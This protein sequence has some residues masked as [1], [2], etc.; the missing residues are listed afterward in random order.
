MLNDTAAAIDS[1]PG[2]ID[3]HAKG[4]QSAKKIRSFVCYFGI[5]T[6]QPQAREP[7]EHR[8]NRDRTFHPRERRA[9]TKVNSFAERNVVARFA[10]N[11]EAIGIRKLRGIA[12]CRGHDYETSE[13]GGKSSP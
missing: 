3:R 1:L 8:A 11:I 2:S 7:L 12:I 6:F 5:R 9:D 4:I 13:I 10:R